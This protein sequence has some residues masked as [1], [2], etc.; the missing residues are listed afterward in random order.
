MNKKVLT[1]HYTL[2][3]KEGQILDSSAKEGPMSCL[4]GVGQIL[5]ALEKVLMGLTVGQKQSVQLSADQ[6]YGQPQT[7]RVVEVPL[8]DL[9]E[10]VAIGDQ[11]QADEIEGSMFRVVN[12]G[13]EFATLDGNHPLA[14]MDLF[15][16][17]ELVEVREATDEELSHGHAHSPHTVH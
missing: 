1:F 11:F 2:K 17:V 7:D 9:P 14:G 3:S 8:E 6:A 16:D 13:E 10:D 15:F 12:I 5:P 4:E